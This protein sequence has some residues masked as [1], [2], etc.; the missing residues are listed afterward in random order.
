MAPIKGHIHGITI[1]KTLDPYST[2]HQ[3]VDL[4]R[5]Y[6]LR[7]FHVTFPDV[8]NAYDLFDLTDA[9]DLR[10]NKKIKFH[11]IYNSPSEMPQRG[12]M[13]IWKPVGQY[14]PTGHVAIM[15]EVVNRSIVTVAEQNGPTQN[16]HRNIRIHHPGII[17]WMRIDFP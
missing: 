13:I 11:M 4:A 1:Y 17:G 2:T 8:Q 12:D 10:T 6:Y 7:K 3:C 5:R 15:K 9:I 16:G 14:H